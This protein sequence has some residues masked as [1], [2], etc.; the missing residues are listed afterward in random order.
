MRGLSQKGG[1]PVQTHSEMFRTTSST[2]DCKWPQTTDHQQGCRY[3]VQRVQRPATHAQEGGTLTRP[4]TTAVKPVYQEAGARSTQSTIDDYAIM[5]PAA[6]G[7]K[8]QGTRTQT[9]HYEV[10]RNKGGIAEGTAAKD[11][12]NES[13]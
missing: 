5:N 7:K 1:K 10:P 3:K 12:R 6:G 4:D 11:D 13:K 9:V 8:R 2:Q